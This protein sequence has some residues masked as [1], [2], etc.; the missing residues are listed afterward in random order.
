[1]EFKSNHQLIDALDH[2]YI[3]SLNKRVSSNKTKPTT[4]NKEVTIDL[5]KCCLKNRLK[6]VLYLEGES[7]SISSSVAM[8]AILN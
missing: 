5:E 3:R 8:Y 1:M 6:R 4:N 2:P 7:D